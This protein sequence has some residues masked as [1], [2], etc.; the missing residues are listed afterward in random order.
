MTDVLPRIWQ[1]AVVELVMVMAMGWPSG[2]YAAVYRCIDGTGSS[3]FTDSPAQ[4]DQCA[5]LL[6]GNASSVATTIRSVEPGHTATV[7]PTALDPSMTVPA[8]IAPGDTPFDPGFTQPAT[9]VSSPAVV[10]NADA[11]VRC[12]PGVNP[13]NPLT[14]LCGPTP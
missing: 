8:A 3:I 2:A 5:P 4:L 13:L 1:Q 11:F 9:S 7:T 6:T 12:I 14:V 10:P